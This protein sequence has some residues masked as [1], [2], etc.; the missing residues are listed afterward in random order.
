MIFHLFLLQQSNFLVFYQKFCMKLLIIF[1]INLLFVRFLD[2]NNKNL[3]YSDSWIQSI[4]SAFRSKLYGIYT[5][6]EEDNI[7]AVFSFYILKKKLLT[8]YGAPIPG[9]FTPYRDPIFF[10]RRINTKPMK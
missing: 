5:Y 7:V 9:S 4:Q 2:L 6:D 8:F 10:P 1:S 3:F